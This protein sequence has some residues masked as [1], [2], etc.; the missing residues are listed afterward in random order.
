MHRRPYFTLI[1][2]HIFP[3]FSFQNCSKLMWGI[4]FFYE[5]EY[6]MYNP[7]LFQFVLVTFY[8][9]VSDLCNK[10]DRMSNTN[11]LY[12]NWTSN[13]IHLIIF[14]YLEKAGK[15]PKNIC[16]I[17]QTLQ[18]GLWRYRFHDQLRSS[19][20]KSRLGQSFLAIK[21]GPSLLEQ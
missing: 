16:L 15:T 11:T 12:Y 5:T 9:M 14:W 19:V 20:V 7:A 10:N 6:L 21:R 4:L 17:V 13:F 3:L 2:H 8:T 18:Q 1:L